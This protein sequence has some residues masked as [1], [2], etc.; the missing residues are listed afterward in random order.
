MYPIRISGF[1][2]FIFW[3]YILTALC[4]NTFLAFHLYTINISL[5]FAFLYSS[6]NILYHCIILIISGKSSRLATKCKEG[7]MTASMFIINS[8]HNKVTYVY[9]GVYLYPQKYLTT[10][11]KLAYLIITGVIRIKLFVVV[12]VLDVV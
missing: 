4:S 5:V 12:L 10:L 9:K 2:L 11:S 8:S 7:L 3:R 6:L 1:Y